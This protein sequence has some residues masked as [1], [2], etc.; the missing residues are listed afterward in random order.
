M[1][2]EEPLY[3]GTTSLLL[4]T[5]LEHVRSASFGSCFTLCV[6]TAVSEM[7]HRPGSVLV[8]VV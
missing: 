4:S 5:S 8:A 3:V 2:L 6:I 1:G 7:Q